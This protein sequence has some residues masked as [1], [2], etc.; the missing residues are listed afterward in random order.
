MFRKLL[1]A[2]KWCCGEL[3]TFTTW[4]KYHENRFFPSLIS[5]I[6]L[7][8]IFAF[9]LTYWPAISPTCTTF[10]KTQSKNTCICTHA[11]QETNQIV[12]P[13]TYYPASLPTILDPAPPLGF[14]LIGR[15]LQ[16]RLPALLLPEHPPDGLADSLSAYTHT[17]TVVVATVTA[18]I[19]LQGGVQNAPNFF[20]VSKHPYFS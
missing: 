10:D 18:I 9:Q 4:K 17:Q 14:I 6:K 16:L 12:S 5:D 19:A 20:F 15:F 3:W 7:L 13:Y 2:K 8:Y 11:L 1:W